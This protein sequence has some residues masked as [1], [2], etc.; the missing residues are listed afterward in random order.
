MKTRIPYGDRAKFAQRVGISPTRLSHVMN[1]TAMPS[2]RELRGV[3]RALGGTPEE[4]AEVLWKRYRERIRER[5][6][7]A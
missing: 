7:N 2:P 3:A 4:L 1:G 5:A 6:K